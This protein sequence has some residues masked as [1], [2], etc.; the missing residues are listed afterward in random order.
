MLR[1]IR[2][3]NFKA[4]GETQEIPIRPITL[5]YGPNSAGKS[6]ILHALAYAHHASRTGELDVHKTE[7]GGQSI[8][9]GGFRQFVHRGDTEEPVVLGFEVDVSGQSGDITPWIA[10][11]NVTIKLDSDQVVRAKSFLIAAGGEMVVSLSSGRDDSTLSITEVDS[12][13]P[14]FAEYWAS[15]C[16]D[17]GVS[18]E[19]GEGRETAF[20]DDVGRVEVVRRGLLP[21]VVGIEGKVKSVQGGGG[22]VRTAQASL[23]ALNAVRALV[24]ESSAAARAALESLAYIGPLRDYPERDLIFR[25]GARTAAAGTGS[26]AWQTLAFNGPARAGVNL[27][28]GAEYMSTP[29]RLDAQ[30]LVAPRELASPV[31]LRLASLASTDEREEPFE[32]DLA[33]TT[34][35]EEDSNPDDFV[36]P[37]RAGGTFRPAASARGSG[38]AGGRTRGTGAGAR[39]VQPRIAGAGGA[40]KVNRAALDRLQ[41]ELLEPVVAETLDWAATA[42]PNR[43]VALTLMDARR[44]T[45]VSFRDVG[46]GVS[47]VLPVLA[48]AF[49]KRGATIA[50]EQPELH[51]HPALQA[52]LGD[53]FVA[54][55][56]VERGNRFILETHSEHILLRVMRR[57]RET[58]DRTLP[59]GA[60]AI[61]TRDVAVLFVER[62]ETQSIVRDMPLTRRGE[63]VKAWPG[64]FFEEGLREVF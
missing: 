53:L 16:A 45:S 17:V 4:F 11:V 30:Q 13:H 59:D 26:D 2:V 39:V 12:A 64:G 5:I 15:A 27:W 49:A 37:R 46:V 41:P 44:R 19:N 21:E 25:P 61:S 24:N 9:L 47:Q 14:V 38:A 22:K 43:L 1:A 62:N 40:R 18:S 3:T 6:S 54:S 60:H 8:D 36:A 23:A 50:I 51:L 42:S 7:L 28:L 31:T 32:P 33:D 20:V 63:L 35:P 34:P 52:E 56:L 58:T 10:S 57:L 29:Y 55:T 48:Y